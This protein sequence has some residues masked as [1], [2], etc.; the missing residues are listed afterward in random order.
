MPGS[1][2]ALSV[3]GQP[4]STGGGRASDRRTRRCERPQLRWERASAADVRVVAGSRRRKWKPRMLGEPLVA[5]VDAA[6]DYSRQQRREHNVQPREW[7]G[8]C[9]LVMT[10][11]RAALVLA[12]PFVR[13]AFLKRAQ[14]G[15]SEGRAG[16][17]GYL[18]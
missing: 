7:R 12:S 16:E 15:L 2:A 6:V 18:H 8:D 1:A 17:C 10:S 4:E 3:E 5:C 14:T 9:Y 13:S 11:I